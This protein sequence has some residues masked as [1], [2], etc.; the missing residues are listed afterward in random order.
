MEK[1]FLHINKP[2][3]QDWDNMTHTDK[4]KYCNNC[5][6]TVFD[7][8]NATDNEIIKHIDKI[9]DE[10]FCGKFQ[11]QQL[12][13][14]LEKS[15]IRKSNHTLYELLISFFL[16]VVSQNVVAQNVS[17]QEKIILKERADSIL[18]DLAIKSEM[19]DIVCDTSKSPIFHDKKIRMGGIRTI[20]KQHNPLVILDGVQIKMAAVGKIDAEKIKSIDVLKANE[21]SAIYGSDGVNGVI[22]ITSKKPQKRKLTIKLP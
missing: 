22:L 10:E 20:S 13:R 9:K 6:K 7:F 16:I 15:T 5:Q 19:P 12:N 4:G 2:C 3:S 18:N 21:A 11:E 14:W 8:T 1:Y 17:K